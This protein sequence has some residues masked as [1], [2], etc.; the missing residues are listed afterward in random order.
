MTK[1]TYLICAESWSGDLR[2]ATDYREFYFKAVGFREA[3][4][5]WLKIKNRFNESDK[6][7]QV[8]IREWTG[9]HIDMTAKRG[10]R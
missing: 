10:Y 2:K 5:A 1:K 4:G 8:L 7:S 6:H 9:N 3:K